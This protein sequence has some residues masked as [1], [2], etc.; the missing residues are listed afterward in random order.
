VKKDLATLEADR[1]EYHRLFTQF[2][3]EQ[4][5]LKLKQQS[6]EHKRRQLEQHDSFKARQEITQLE[7]ALKDLQDRK[8]S[9][10]S[11][12]EGKKSRERQ[13]S[14]EYKNLLGRQEEQAAVVENLLA[15]MDETAERFYFYEHA[16]AQ[17]E[18]QKEMSR[19]YDF[20]LLKKE[21]EKYKEKITNAKKAL[22]KERA[23][24]LLYDRALEELEAARRERENAGRELDRTEAVLMET[25]EEFIERVYA[26]EK[27]NEL[28]KLP[29]EAM[30]QISR[31]VLA[32][33][34]DSSYNDVISEVYKY[35]R[36]IDTGFR[37]RIVE[38]ENVK[39]E[40]NKQLEQ[41]QAELEEWKSRREPEPPSEDKVLAARQK[42][43]REGIPFVPLYKAVDFRDDVPELIR[44]RI[45]EA[46]MDM[47]LLNALIVPEKYREALP[48]ME[49]D[50]GDRFIVPNP[51]FYAYELS[52]LLKPVEP[53]D[54]SVSAEEIDDVLKSIMLD[55]QD[56]LAYLNE[57]G[58]YS[59]GILNG[60]T[61]SRYVPRF[62]GTEARKRHKLENIH[63]LEQDIH[64]LKSC[65]EQADSNIR[66]L[67]GKQEQLSFERDRFPERHDL[68]TAAAMVYSAR[69]VLD[70]KIKECESKEASAERA[71]KAL[72]E[73]RELVQEHTGKMEIPA[74]LEAFV[75]ADEDALQYRVLLG[76][77]ETQHV[78]LVQLYREADNIQGQID[79][80][81]GDMD[82]LLYDL[83]KLN[84]DIQD[85][86]AKKQNYEAL[87]KELNYEEIQKEVDEC[88][89]VLSA[90]PQLSE[91]AIRNAQTYKEKHG[92]VLERIER[93][94]ADAEYLAQRNKCL[95]DGFWQEYCLAYVVKYD[96]SNADKTAAIEQNVLKLAR[97]V[98]QDL[99]GIEKEGKL[100]EDYATALQERYHQNRHYFTE[101]NLIIEYIFEQVPAFDDDRLNKAAAGQKRLE[102]SARIQGRDVNF[103]SLA[104]FLDDSIEENEKLL[105]ESDRQLFEDILANTV[106]K[107]I[108]ARIYHSEQ[109]VKKMNLLMESMNTSSGLSFSLVWKNRTA[110]T[111]EQL[112]T[113][114]LVE[115]LKS[116]AG[117][118]REED[119][120]KLAAHFRSKIAQ[121]RKELEEKGTTQTFHTIMKD[122]LDYRKW[123]EF[124]LFYRK[125]GEPRKELTNNAF[126]KFSGGEKA[127][128][129]YV[130][131]FSAVYARY[132]GAR[133]D[134]PRIISLDEAFAGVDE[135][136]I[137][138]MFRLLEELKLNFIINSQILWGDYDTVPA[139]SICELIRP[140]N[141]DFVTVIRYHWNGKVRVLMLDE[142]EPSLTEGEAA[143]ALL[144]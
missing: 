30:T 83:N 91:N 93:R 14:N 117:L 138:D 41:K 40:Y 48:S 109:W 143:A 7:V 25:R 112:D 106:G 70:A 130:P 66:E 105:R 92:T 44:G 79:D 96:E 107:K 67:M 126:Y 119:M 10:E 87:L 69:L 142:E 18:L 62:I 100:R 24:S 64:E 19:E 108:R 78:K 53:E 134:C 8:H 111:E 51:Q 128:A 28:L 38:A 104:D 65:L 123:F 71:H 101:Y 84:W 72:K 136:N 45:E 89:R 2:E 115:I 129:M 50:M 61:T 144:E 113:R 137:R 122:V 125:T 31:A 3:Q 20:R 47:G 77:L 133:K 35:H 75:E 42:L 49:E 76:T 88:I 74:R 120:E 17:A 68:D 15:E 118:L 132:E 81:L 110:E 23:Q 21:I 39:A 80:V 9:K 32:Y 26:W 16:F 37:Q 99:K 103:Y 98:C 94:K 46:L 121:A 27:G 13:L 127:M 60:K 139:L 73:L 33:G 5:S 90:I 82:D 29:G 56:G 102:L 34:K 11:S 55:K 141:A 43:N 57:S 140:N 36:E 59:I 85:A 124:Q 1:D 12:L 6:Y 58:E 114:E 131:L 116:D 86:R 54:G 135:N 95:K 22:E 4:E 97:K 63:R 52:S